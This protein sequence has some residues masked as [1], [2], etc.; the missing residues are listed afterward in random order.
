DVPDAE[1]VLIIG[2]A[3]AADRKRGTALLAPIRTGRSDRQNKMKKPLI[4]VATQTIEAGVDIDLDGL[5]TEAAAFDALR[6]RF[7]RLNRAGRPFTPVAAVVAHRDDIAGKIDD[8]VYR[9]RISKTWAE[10]Y[11]LARDRVLNFGVEAFVDRLAP[12]RAAE[13]ATPTENAPVLLPA[14]AD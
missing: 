9:D 14:Y 13:L 11:G 10:L 3:R 2:P 4:V 1:V 8:P 12:K 5:V 7:G 6:Q